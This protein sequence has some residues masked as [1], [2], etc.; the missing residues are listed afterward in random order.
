MQRIRL[1]V[2]VVLAGLVAGGLA[3]VTPV[4]AAVTPA[5]PSRVLDTRNG[6][7]GV[8]GVV[9]P[10]QVVRVAAPSAAAGASSL[11]LNVT[12]TD[13][14]APGFVTVWPCDEAKPATSN[15][16]FVPGRAIP[17]MAI[18]RPSAASGSKGQF[19]LEA[20]APVHLLVDVM[21]W[22]SGTGDVVPTAPNR[23]VD[24]RQ[25]RDPL[26]QG[27]FRRVRVGGTAGVPANAS[28][29]LLNVTLTGTRDAGFA[30]VVPCPASGGP[31]PSTSTLNF[32]PGD[33]VPA[34]TV[35]A[36]VNGDV[37]VYSNSASDLIVDTFGWSPAGG[38]LQVKSPER[39]L[40]TR[41]GLWSTGPAR[42]S[43]VI[44][45]RVAGRG[46]I[47]NES[48]AAMLT[49]TI[50]DTTS[51]GYVT[52]WPCDVPQPET[53][54]LNFWPAV[55]RANSVLVGLSTTTGE[56]CLSAFTNDGSNVSLIADAVGWVPGTVSRGPV[57]APPTPPVRSV[58]EVH[59]V[60]RRRGIAQRRRLRRPGPPHCG[61]PPRERRR[62]RQPRQ[63]RQRQHTHRL[64]T[65]QTCRR[66]LHR[67]HRRDHPMGRMQMGHRRRHRPRP[68]DQRVL[69]VPI[70]Q[71]RQRRILGPRPSPR[72]RPPIRVPVPGQRSHLIGLQPR[73]HL[74]HLASLL[75]RRLHLAV[76]GPYKAGDAWGCVGVWFSGQWYQNNADYIAAVQANYNSKV[77]LTSTFIN[78]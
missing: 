68:S 12:A 45:I 50:S 65:I 44:R 17:N 34:F 14:L 51:S 42:S 11:S 28:S 78:G 7:G 38:G 77:W 76:G 3:T 20:S 1:I 71:R 74:R 52:A 30:S 6:V 49:V 31:I 69:L 57:P 15:L 26:R 43:E 29:A 61:D 72:H 35:A 73:L 4:D 16:N 2:A 54:V 59:D 56:V 40:D 60:A 41:S 5:V 53:S 36:L 24:T 22:F 33:T 39:V 48:L 75:R 66:Q 47:P 37:C 70:R 13:A 8:L 19:C 23:I 55:A 9:V 64:V 67:H 25:T 32:A 63:Q 46:G 27:E 62:Q 10:G 21:G 18:I 58:G